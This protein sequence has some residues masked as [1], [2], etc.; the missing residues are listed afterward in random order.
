MLG[1]MSD[2]SGAQTADIR[3]RNRIRVCKRCRFS[4]TD[5]KEFLHHQLNAHNDNVELHSCDKCDYMTTSY[6]EIHKHKKTHNATKRMSTDESEPGELYNYYLMA[7]T[8]FG[9]NSL[10]KKYNVQHFGRHTLF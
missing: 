3:G 2:G 9:S 10:P 7:L 1:T 8:C 4:T 6:M 5:P